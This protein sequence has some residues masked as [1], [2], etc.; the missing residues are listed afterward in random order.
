MAYEQDFRQLSAQYLAQGQWDM[1]YGTLVDLWHQ[2]PSLA[3]AHYLLASYAR[4]RQH[5][6]LTPCRLALLRSFTV[7]PLVPLLQAAACAHGIAL[8]VHVGAFNTYV[9][10]ILDPASALYR[11]APDVVLLA[12]QTRDI[13]PELW[14]GYADL[15][16]EAH[17]AAISRTID[18]LHTC[19]TT[20]RSRSQAHL[21]VHTLE[22]PALPSQGV[23][24]Q[25]SSNGQVGAIQEINTA[26][27]QLANQQRGVYVLEY[28]AVVARYGRIHWYDERKWLTTR[29][30]ISAN[31]LAPMAQEW[32]RFLAPLT[33][34]VCKA[35][36]VD[37][38]NTLWGGV[39]GED[40]M[41]GI[42]LGL[43]YP[44]AAYQ[45]LQRAILDLYQRGI[46]LAVCSKNNFDDA[47]E[48]LE[49]HPGM[50]LRPQHFAAWRINWQDKVQNLREI[51]AELNI[52]IDAL[53]FLDDNPVER[54]HIRADLPEVTVLP[55]P[56]DPMG[57]AAALRATPVFERLVL[58]DEDRERGRYYAEQRQRVELEQR[59]TSLEDFYASL[60]QEVE[61]RSVD[62]TS[63]TRAAQL[64]Q[65]T[66]QFN[67]TTHRYSEQQI[68]TMVENPDWDVYT[69][70]VRD[71]FGDNGI[72]GVVI[73]HD[74][75]NVSDIDTFLLSC[76]VISRGVETSILSFLVERA[77]ARQLRQVQGWFLPT[78]K[79]A[80]A[81]DC[82]AEHHMK[83]LAEQDDGTLWALDL[84]TQDIAC[85]PWIR[86]TTCEGVL[87][88]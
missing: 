84:V 26:L 23:F 39:I 80:P 50:L 49:G 61:I 31:C 34:R 70:R 51:A 75:D 21:I 82:Y 74:G 83:A 81:R 14:S 58:S 12:I 55:L 42:Q 64:T 15:T 54:A 5:V 47:M 25:Q 37:L 45:A 88:R 19:I 36:V 56:D 40:G 33:G 4:L 9:Q 30:P 79:N 2:Q 6:P 65:K 60:Q 3:T 18:S 53:A 38:D 68:S 86:L 85:P 17:D 57:Y 7:E 44:G 69:V 76:R 10:D 52:G 87:S 16:A 72:V 35:L 59:A 13:V 73:V 63:L 28:D 27:R 66:N 24:D 46:I 62:P 77:R 20:L 32:L 48:A 8:E 43:E 71:R 41:E 67:T 78:K 29:L 22:T 1:A 11:F